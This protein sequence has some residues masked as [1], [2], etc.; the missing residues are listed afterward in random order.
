MVES[1]KIAH[2]VIA[3]QLFYKTADVKRDDESL[4]SEATAKSYESNSLINIGTPGVMNNDSRVEALSVTDLAGNAQSPRTASVR[5]QHEATLKS[6]KT[7]E[8]TSFSLHQPANLINLQDRNTD[9][10]VTSENPTSAFAS[11]VRG[12]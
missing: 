6:R 9:T 1:P 10:D 11:D 5:E 4:T 7:D 12:R 8:V 3:N 2:P